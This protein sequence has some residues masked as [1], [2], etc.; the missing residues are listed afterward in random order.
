MGA[1]L[2][3]RRLR[4]LRRAVLAAGGHASPEEPRGVR[5]YFAPAAPAGGASCRPAYSVEPPAGT[6]LPTNGAGP[7]RR[8]SGAALLLLFARGSS[9]RP[10]FQGNYCSNNSIFSWP[11]LP[12]QRLFLSLSVYASAGVAAANE[13]GRGALLVLLQ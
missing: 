3:L 5:Q 11:F 1:A 10:F 12:S 13:W 7:G 9:R 2:P 4:S 6:A 8:L